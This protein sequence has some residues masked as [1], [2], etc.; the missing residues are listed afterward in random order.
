MTIKLQD[1]ILQLSIKTEHTDDTQADDEKGGYHFR[2]R[3]LGEFYR[4][5]TLSG[6]ADA[7][8]IETVYHNGI[9]IIIIPKVKA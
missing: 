2:E 5:I 9:L 3:F 8:K 4:A 1:K 6:T 7:A